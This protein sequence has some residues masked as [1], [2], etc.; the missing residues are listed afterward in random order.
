MRA[1][2]D[3]KLGYGRELTKSNPFSAPDVS[4]KEIRRRFGLKVRQAQ[5]KPRSEIGACDSDLR[6]SHA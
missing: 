3:T 4:E 1:A 2:H 5:N 6:D